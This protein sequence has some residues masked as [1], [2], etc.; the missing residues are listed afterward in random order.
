MPN[1]EQTRSALEWKYIDKLSVREIAE[2]LDVTE[3]AAESMLF[4]GRREF[5]ERMLLKD[6]CDGSCRLAGAELHGMPSLNG[7]AD[8]GLRSV[9]D[10]AQSVDV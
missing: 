9:Q 7:H 10:K 6:D 1:T 2:R 3:K 8:P 5:R 4:R